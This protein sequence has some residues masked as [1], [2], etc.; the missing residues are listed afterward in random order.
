MKNLSLLLLLF[1]GICFSQQKY[2]TT[3]ISQLLRPDT[4]ISSITIITKIFAKQAGNETW[5]KIYESEVAVAKNKNAKKAKQE[6]YEKAASQIDHL[7][8]PKVDTLVSP[9]SGDAPAES[10]VR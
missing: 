4:S 1:S 3:K 2:S 9:Q 10:L 6:E 7:L 8:H 5:D